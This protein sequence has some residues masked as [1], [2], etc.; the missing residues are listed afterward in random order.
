MTEAARRDSVL[1][2]FDWRFHL[3]EF[4]G[5]ERAG[6]DDSSWECV[7][8]PKDF[9]LNMPWNPG[10]KPSRGFKDMSGAWFRKNFRPDESW[11]GRRVMLDFEGLM[12]YG[13][14]YPVSYNNLKLPT[15][16]RV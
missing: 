9:Q 6:T 13:D 10:A 4:A 1:F 14:V 11:K 15:I 12:Y 2:N 3:G 5:G 8:L 16:L 7:D